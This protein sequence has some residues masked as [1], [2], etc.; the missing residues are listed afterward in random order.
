MEVQLP[1]EEKQIAIY[2]QRSHM[3]K[4]SILLAVVDA[5]LLFCLFQLILSIF[6][7]FSSLQ[8]V[9]AL[10]IVLIC[11]LYLIAVMAIALILPPFCWLNFVTIRN[12]LSPS[13]VLSMDKQGITIYA[14]PIIKSVF[15]LGTP[16][17]AFIS[18]VY[19]FFKERAFIFLQ[20]V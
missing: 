4:F 6:S 18:F 17:Q 3:V 1:Q 20:R 12:L 19:L 9:P 14:Q 16:S 8:G 10:A 2:S 15:S 7:N 11:F 13:C 5:F